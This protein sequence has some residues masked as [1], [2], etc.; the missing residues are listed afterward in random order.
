MTVAVVLVSSNFAIAQGIP[1]IDAASIYQQVI[2]V[3]AWVDQ[4]KGMQDQLNQQV[5]LVNSLGGSRGLG[6]FLNDPTL[7][8]ALPPQL[9]Q[10]Y[11]AIKNGG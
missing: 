9:M 1:V 8:N 10:V 4:L 3:K 6:N 7:L 5:A 11:T 2:R